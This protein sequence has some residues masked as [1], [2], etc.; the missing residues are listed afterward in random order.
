MNASNFRVSIIVSNRNGEKLLPRLF[1][2]LDVQEN[3]N[4]EYEIIV[5]DDASTDASC[6]LVLKYNKKTRL[7]RNER[8]KG[9]AA[10]KNTG[11]KKAKYEW[12][13]FVDNDVFLH[14]KCLQVLGAAVIRNHT[15]C[16]QPKIMFADNPS[17]INSAGGIIN[18]SGYARDRG[19][20]EKD[21]G[22][23]MEEESVAFASS[24]AMLIKRS[25]FFKLGGFDESYW[26][27][28]EDADLGYRLYANGGKINYIP[29]AVCFHNMSATFGRESLRKKILFERNRM[30]LA[31][32]NFQLSTLLKNIFS[33]FTLKRYISLFAQADV[34][35]KFLL[36][37]AGIIS[38][39]GFIFIFPFVIIKR[40]MRENVRQIS[41]KEFFDFFR[42]KDAINCART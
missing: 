27:G 2:S 18:C 37:F 35:N 14:G 16:L 24:A 29:D 34:R 21:N 15:V 42:E 8:C 1:D 20:F 13:L 30:L 26:Y 31:V 41:D 23:Y 40:L 25:R 28:Y 11:A 5:V 9:P 12:L 38:V 19:I 10:V 4:G 33:G 39:C 3:F 17:V 7:I 22:Q 32:K 6:E 36:V